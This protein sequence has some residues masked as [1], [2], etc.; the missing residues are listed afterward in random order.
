MAP[1]TFGATEKL[2]E[3]LAAELGP[4]M[5]MPGALAGGDLVLLDQNPELRRHPRAESLWVVSEEAGLRV[6]YVRMGGNTLYLAHQENVKEPKSWTAVPLKGKGPERV[7]RAR[8][9]WLGR[10][11][12]A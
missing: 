11:L 10:A 8:V 4:D 3:P 5:V 9:A 12:A 2:V 1:F 7:V 6:R